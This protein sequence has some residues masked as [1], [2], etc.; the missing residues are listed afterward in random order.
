MRK[1]SLT[2]FSADSTKILSCNNCMR[3]LWRQ[4]WRKVISNQL[5]SQ[6]HPENIWYLPHRPVTNPN[7][8]VKVMCVLNAAA[9]F[10]RQS[11]KN[12]SGPDLVNNL[13]GL[14]LRFCQDPNAVMAD[15][16]ARFLRIC[17][18]TKDQ[19]CLRFLWLSKISTLQFQ[20]TQFIFGA[21]CSPTTAI[22]VLQQTA[23]DTGN[24]NTT[25]D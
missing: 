16:E 10:K 11:L 24:T 4:I 3:K 17:I 6:I 12:L 25:E 18:R 14:I 1:H 19:S 8:P 2:A 23:K 21:T 5:L 22:F 9:V 15:I 7:K 20:Y 13:V